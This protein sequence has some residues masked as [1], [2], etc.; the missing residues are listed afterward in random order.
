MFAEDKTT[1]HLIHVKVK[2]QDGLIWILR[3][4]AIA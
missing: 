1:F 3:S 4:Y 2:L